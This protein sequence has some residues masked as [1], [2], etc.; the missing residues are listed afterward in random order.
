MF[1]LILKNY[2]YSKKGENSRTTHVKVMG[3][4]SELSEFWNERA[5]TFVI[6]F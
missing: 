3:S 6:N 1:F 4:L 5:A 2:T